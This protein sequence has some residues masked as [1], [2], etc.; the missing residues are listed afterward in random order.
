MK[1]DSTLKTF[2]ESTYDASLFP[3]DDRV[4]P[5]ELDGISMQ[6]VEEFAQVEREN[7]RREKELEDIKNG[8]KDTSEK[9]DSL[10]VDPYSKLTEIATVEMDETISVAYNVTL[11]KVE[12]QSWGDFTDTSYVYYT[13]TLFYL[14]LTN[15]YLVFTTLPS[16]LTSW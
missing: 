16:T 7:L 13:K 11:M 5:M 6:Q 12:L 2:A 14:I 4:A 15:L 1:L 8:V 3:V 10:K 9:D